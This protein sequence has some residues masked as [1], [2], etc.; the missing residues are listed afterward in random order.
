MG[1]TSK[2]AMGLSVAL[3]A[4]APTAGPGRVAGNAAPLPGYPTS[5]PPAVQAMW[6]D[7]RAAGAADRAH[8]YPEAVRLYQQ[9]DAELD[10]GAAFAGGSTADSNFNRMTHCC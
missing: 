7:L 9:I 1:T 5:M 10:A 2:V 4:C 3:G 6:Q 8:N